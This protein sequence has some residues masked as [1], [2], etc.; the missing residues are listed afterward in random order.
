MVN[1]KGYVIRTSPCKP[2]IEAASFRC[3]KCIK[4]TWMKFEDGI[5][6]PPLI[7]NIDK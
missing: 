2:L 4:E 7:C 1:I 5:F 3:I 6:T